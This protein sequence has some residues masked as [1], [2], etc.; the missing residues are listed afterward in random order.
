MSQQPPPPPPGGIQPLSS[1][2]QD[3]RNLSENSATTLAEL[4]GF[5][6]QMR[7][8]SPAEMLGVVAQSRIVGS[9]LLAT[10]LVAATIAIFTIGPFFWEKLKPEPRT[11]NPVVI[12]TPA[13]SPQPA[14]TPATGSETTSTSPEPKAENPPPA[15]DGLVGIGPV[16][17][18][19]LEA[20]A[21]R[22]VPL[23]LAD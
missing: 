10:L 6:G 3:L 19:R 23:T 1:V 16:V 14:P 2:R 18:H 11:V 12:T 20:V 7:G 8:K 22:R 15:E 21:D 5:L 4:Q 9:T 13:S 17:D